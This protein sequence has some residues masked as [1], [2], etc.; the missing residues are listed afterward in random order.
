[1]GTHLAFGAFEYTASNAQADSRLMMSLADSIEGRFGC[2]RL[3][4][5]RIHR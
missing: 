3:L 4:L 1:M 5:L 2:L